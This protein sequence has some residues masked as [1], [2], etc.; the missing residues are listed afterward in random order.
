MKR[1]IIYLLAV[2]I[3]IFSIISISGCGMVMLVSVLGDQAIEEATERADI[4]DEGVKNSE[5]TGSVTSS[6]SNSNANSK[7]DTMVFDGE[8]IPKGN[9][10]GNYRV[11]IKSAR[12]G[13]D[14]DG[15]NIIIIKYSFTNN[16]TEPASFS[17]A[18][19][20]T[21]YQSG[22]ELSES[23]GYSDDQSISFEEKYVDIK[24]GA[25]I[26]VE[27]AYELRNLSDKIEAEVSSFKYDLRDDKV[28][29]I[30]SFK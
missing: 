2:L 20:C 1:G 12:L 8:N 15:K 6:S 11:E 10:I 5:K 16:D 22:I 28:T 29:G 25:T 18:F 19:D 17:Y 3:L 24:K 27:I 14:Y 26:E 13:K 21:A 4:T 30:F 9:N 7:E 23:L